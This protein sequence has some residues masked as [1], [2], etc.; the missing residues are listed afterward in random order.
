MCL[1]TFGHRLHWKL[2]KFECVVLWTSNF[3]L[4]GNSRSHSLHLNIL[5]CV[6]MNES[7]TVDAT[8]SELS[9]CK[10]SLDEKSTSEPSVSLSGFTSSTNASSMVGASFTFIE[11]A[12]T[13]NIFIK[14]DWM[15]DVK[16]SSCIY[17]SLQCEHTNARRSGV[18]WKISPTFSR[19]GNGLSSSMSNDGSRFIVA[20]PAAAGTSAQSILLFAVEKRL[21]RNWFVYVV[22]ILTT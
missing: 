9:S 22:F 20:A 6:N 11:S 12:N 14:C 1:N 19:L 21:E 8:R 16:S 15:C 4:D 18:R 7:S 2:A 5:L 13:V 3:D 17:S 10:L